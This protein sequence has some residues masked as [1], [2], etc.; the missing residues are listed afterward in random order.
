MLLNCWEVWC[1]LL[2]RE[3]SKDLRA[4]VAKA[5]R[6][7][8]ILYEAILRNSWRQSASNLEKESSTTILKGSRQ[9][10]KW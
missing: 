1:S 7:R 2:Q 3:I 6:K 10:P 9:T 8:T 5:E 4:K